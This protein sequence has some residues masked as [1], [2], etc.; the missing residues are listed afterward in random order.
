MSLYKITRLTS[1]KE[2]QRLSQIAQSPFAKG[3]LYDQLRSQKSDDPK[4]LSGVND[5]AASANEIKGWS[6]L[7]IKGGDFMGAEGVGQPA[8]M[9]ISPEI[10]MQIDSMNIPAEE[11]KRLL[12]RYMEGELTGFAGQVKELAY[13]ELIPKL[14]ILHRQ[15]MT[16][17][18]NAR[19]NFMT[20]AKS[21]LDKFKGSMSMSD[22]N[23]IRSNFPGFARLF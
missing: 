1:E 19:G 12:N 22:L 18:P 6:G 23:Y 21:I 14:Q 8:E 10:L 4:E 5:T 3:P 9:T 2:N 13:N 17:A 15:F 20:E 11:K 7:G 16:S